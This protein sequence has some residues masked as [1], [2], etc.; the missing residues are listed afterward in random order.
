LIEVLSCRSQ[1]YA[2][3]TLLRVSNLFIELS[4]AGLL[5]WSEARHFAQ[6]AVQ[7]QVVQ[8]VDVQLIVFNRHPTA[9]WH[10]LRL[11][12]GMTIDVKVDL[13]DFEEILEHWIIEVS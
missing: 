8:V 10:W 3:L 5:S 13:V 6:P 1:T 4:F 12:V 7:L 9:V 11:Y 2:Q